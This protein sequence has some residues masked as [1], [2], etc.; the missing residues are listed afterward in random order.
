MIK[1]EPLENHPELVPLC[2][3]WNFEAWGQSAGL[4]MEDEVTAFLGFLAP[5]GRQKA[6]VAFISGLPVGLVLL[7]DNDL[8]THRHLKPWLASLFVIPEMRDR[9][10]G[11][12]LVAA[13]EAAA[14]IQ[15]HRELYLYTSK[16]GYYRGLGWHD[17]EALTGNRAG[18]MILKRSLPILLP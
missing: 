13:T 18:L 4:T 12:A 9:G 1:V 6:F 15:G 3:R 2:A 11:K 10:V 16:P 8:E 7:I 17:F 5:S 14:H